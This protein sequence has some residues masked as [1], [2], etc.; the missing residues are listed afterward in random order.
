M[1]FEESLRF[2]LLFKLSDEDR[3]ALCQQIAEACE[4]SYRRGFQQ[5]YEGAADVTVDV[6]EWRFHEPLWYSP[7]PHGTY[8]GHSLIRHA[9][10]VSLPIQ[11]S[12]PVE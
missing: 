8:E 4:Q 10:E 5:G 2:G 12:Q 11:E 9:H 3:F 1:K 6:T 7:S